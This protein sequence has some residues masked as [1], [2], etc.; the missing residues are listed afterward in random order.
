MRTGNPADDTQ[1]DVPD[2]ASG[3]RAGP[4]RAG[5]PIEE[6]VI[7]AII[8]AVLFAIALLM[9]L[10]RF[11]IGPLDATFFEYAGLIGVAL[12]LAGIGA[13]YRRRVRS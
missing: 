11:S 8:A 2:C 12:H 5:P 3:A 13:A 1:P 7:S 10:A 9:H 6:V 4:R